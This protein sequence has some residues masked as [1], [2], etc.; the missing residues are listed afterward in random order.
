MHID[1]QPQT[2]W[3]DE[4]SPTTAAERAIRAEGRNARRR[5]SKEKKAAG[6]AAKA[7]HLGSKVSEAVRKVERGEMT[8][9]ANESTPSTPKGPPSNAPSNPDETTSAPPSPTQSA[10]TDPDSLI[11]SPPPAPWPSPNDPTI[12][13]QLNLAAHRR[14]TRPAHLTLDNPS[15]FPSFYVDAS[16]IH[17]AQAAHEAHIARVGEEWLAKTPTP[18]SAEFREMLTTYLPEED[19]EEVDRLVEMADAVAKK[20]VDVAVE[21]AVSEARA[22][23]RA[24]FAGSPM[25]TPAQRVAFAEA[26]GGRTPASTTWAR[27][28]STLTVPATPFL[29][30]VPSAS[31]AIPSPLSA[32]YPPVTPR[33][34]FTPFPINTQS[35]RD[36]GLSIQIHIHLLYAK[37]AISLLATSSTPP[38]L[39][40]AQKAAKHAYTALSLARDARE[41][42]GVVGRCT[43]YVGV[44]EWVLQELRREHDNEPSVEYKLGDLE[45]WDDVGKAPVL[46][47]FETAT[48]AAEGGFAEGQWAE[49]WVEFLEGQEARAEGVLGQQAQRRESRTWAGWLSN[50]RNPFRQSLTP[51]DEEV[52]SESST[53]AR[54]RARKRA[55]HVDF[56]VQSDF[57]SG[58]E[59][60]AE[61]ESKGENVIDEDLASPG[62]ESES[63]TTP[64]KANCSLPQTPELR[65]DDGADPTSPMSSPD[66]PLPSPTRPRSHNVKGA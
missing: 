42:S 65:G 40:Q 28:G 10:P 22:E 23:E 36:T 53:T 8:P 19:V 59:G 45:D 35:I 41:G 66:T 25:L 24:M 57:V 2:T 11:A 51:R 30:G 63:F 6:E 54:A 32:L 31:L 46:E 27:L 38:T 52:I 44:W 26:E 13:S 55:E 4:V 12:A 48:H 21:V 18:T 49:D 39:A 64:E 33:T 56:L 60:E 14:A 15:P 3:N 37:Q 29:A 58:P 1:L 62:N 43:Y 61:A 16:A 50:L 20:R 17:D 7:E 9:K 47:Y 5:K 34:P